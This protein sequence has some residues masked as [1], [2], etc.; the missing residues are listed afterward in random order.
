MAAAPL[1]GVLSDLAWAATGTAGA[2][3]GPVEPFRLDDV[4][5]LPG[6]FHAAQEL[7]GRYLL[8]LEPDRL[9]HN[10]RVNAGLEPR[11]P[12]YGGWESQEPWVGIR[13]HG[14]T[15]GHYLSAC[16][17]MAAATGLPAYA[18]RVDRIV[19]ELADCQEAGRTGL[20][21]AFP[22]GD[23]QLLNGL[24][25]RPVVG[26]PWYT[27]HKIMAGLRDAHLMTRNAMALP[28]LTRLGDWIDH[29]AKDC[30]EACFQ[31]M[32][33]VEHGG[34]N[35]VLADLHALTGDM[36]YLALAERFNHRALLDPLADGHDP[37]DGWHS[38]TQIPKVVGFARLHGLTGNPRYRNASRFF[39]RSV[40]EHRS[41]ATGGNGDGEH[42][43]PAGENR[44]HVLSARTMETCSTHNMLKLTRALFM[45]EP[46]AAYAEYYERALVNGILASQDP[47]SGMMTYFQATRP[48][49]PKLYCRPFDAFWCCTGTGIENHA[50]Y[51]DSIYFHDANSLVV[52]LFIA[53]ELD[54][55]A[56]RV[57]VRQTTRFPD[58]AATRFDIQVATPTSLALRIR[59]PG[60]C[61]EVGITLNGAPV[62]SRSVAGYIEIRHVWHDGDV[63]QVQLPMHLWLE[64]LPGTYDVVALMY[65]PIALAA[66]LGNEGIAPGSDLI[67]NERTYGSVLDRP[68]AMPEV[69]LSEAALETRVRREPGS[70]LSFRM[71]TNLS[72]ADMELIPFHRIAHER[73]NLYW[74]R[75]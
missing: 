61:H 7:D 27:L 1:L 13:C 12:V 62:G 31:Q 5:L 55:A 15:L 46:D 63:L 64:R 8:A 37:L 54:W 14:H 72:D 9:L 28:V 40:I 2:L 34:M 23:E 24:L 52:N 25:G 44:T 73:Y 74:Q 17:M 65:G 45:A 18:D 49:Y 70:V 58:E 68:I 43:F 60:W 32:L 56:K 35:E 67:A 33:G 69:S 59:H 3:S 19:S 75:V 53:S 20:V 38:N 16:A 48:G 42:F 66:R 50:K 10:F 47:D 4:R 26:V 51:G 39:W 11:A 21:C 6:P 22:D 29:A 30:D 36:R 57:Q 41:F 71:R